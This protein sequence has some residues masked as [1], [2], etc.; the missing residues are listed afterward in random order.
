M[1]LSNLLLGVFAAGAL[2]L[3][4]SAAPKTKS[5][6][7]LLIAGKPSHPTLMH[8]Y[9]AGCSLLK[10]CLDN[11]KGVEAVLYT[12]GWPSDP[13]AFDGA[14]AVFL[15]MDG[16]GGHEAVKPEN[17]KQL[18][19]LMNKGV[20]MGCVHFAV[21]VPADKGGKEWM[22]WIGGYYETAYSCNPIWEPDYQ[23]F[24]KHPITRGVKPFQVKDEWYMHMRFRP[25]MKGVT[26][27][28]VAKPSD[29]VRN[30]PYVYPQGPYPHIQADSGK[31]EIMMWAA[32][33]PDGGRGFG[34]TGG[35]F[36]LNWGNDNFRKLVLN[37][38]VW[39]AK[40]DVPKNG[41]EST[42]TPEDLYANLD[43]K[44][45]KPTGPPKQ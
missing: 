16:A 38:L 43:D 4:G 30:G 9:K 32:E 44:P 25:E 24:P 14:D 1:I 42:V 11:V 3:S 5:H 33:R 2:T 37:A 26:P 6:R 13:H 21:E 31:D 28:L 22:D 19:E 7:I 15:F 40:G 27:I 29:K 17:L 34:F 35:H 45:G 12:N 20:G 36:H 23:T 39:I 18:G 41:I 8:E 10:K